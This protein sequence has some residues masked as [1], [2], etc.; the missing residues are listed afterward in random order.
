[1]ALKGP[2]GAEWLLAA[3]LFATGAAAGDTRV[4]DGDSLRLGAQEI[5]L[6]G[7]DAP[8]AR[9]MCASA[10]GTPWAC[11]RAAADRLAELVAQGPVRC[12]PEDT[13]RYGRLVSTC[14]AGGVD[15]GGRLVAEGLARAYTQFSDAYVALEAEARAA[16]RGIWQGQAEAPWEH[17]AAERAGTGG[18][19]PAAG[20]APSPGCTI[21][22]NVSA[23]GERIY[24]L[25]GGPGYAQT[26]IDPSRG[27]A[28][29]CDEEAARAAG[30]RAPRGAR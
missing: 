30:F 14:T 1:M 11:G 13:D 8:E 26:R 18:F 16:G 12:R 20:A 19:V 17:R 4:K 27:E 22:G 15:L 3:L 28:W 29:F 7:V 21:K 23:G 2:V 10:D 6:F 25:P 5:R 9:Q 24:H